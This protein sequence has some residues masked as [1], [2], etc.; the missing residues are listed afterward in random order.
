MG[1]SV[2]ILARDNE[3]QIGACLDSVSWADERIVLLDTRSQ[4]GTA[5]VAEARGA[6]VVRHRFGDFGAQREFGLGLPSHPWLLYVDSDERATPALGAEIRR[7]VQQEAC[8]GWW[9]PRRNLIWGHEIA[10]GGWYP[11]YQ[12]RLLKLGHA[13]YDPA[14][15]VHEVVL[16]DGRAGH[17]TEPLVHHNYATAAEFVHKQRGYI[18]YEAEI[19]RDRGVRPK[20][21]TYISQPL[22]EFWRRYV[23]LQGY[24]DGWAG[25]ALCALVAYYYGFRTTV[26][27]GRL[28]R[29]G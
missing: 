10:H 7:V 9:V 24:R 19:L 14:R 22:R 11:D 29:G 8:V 12:L 16:L 13:H 17:L 2:A 5:A 25:L 15:P 20:P 18:A 26:A 1:I 4:D 27:L 23:V 21:W 28:R 6:R 3:A